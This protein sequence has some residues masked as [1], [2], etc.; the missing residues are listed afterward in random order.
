MMQ[1]EANLLQYLIFNPLV[2][3]DC[4]QI[5]DPITPSTTP[6]T[7]KP[8]TMTTVKFNSMIHEILELIAKYLL[9]GQTVDT[10][11]VDDPIQYVSSMHH[12]C[13]LAKDQSRGLTGLQSLACTSKTLHKFVQP[14]LTR[15]M[16][17]SN[18]HLTLWPISLDLLRAKQN[19]FL[20]R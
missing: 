3:I 12:S 18:H 7:D 1:T 16:H 17:F 5:T 20:T 9:V 2:L 8:P 6:L 19:I 15:S 13:H 11:T 14:F 10:C 4:I